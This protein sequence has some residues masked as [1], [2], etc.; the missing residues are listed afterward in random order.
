MLDVNP[1]TIQQSSHQELIGCCHILSDECRCS[2][3]QCRHLA[4]A[5]C[6]P[7][8]VCVRQIRH[9]NRLVAETLKLVQTPAHVSETPCNLQA[10]LC[11]HAVEAQHNAQPDAALDRLLVFPSI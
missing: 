11:N 2:R 8:Q 1:Y 3:V 4:E 9:V 5:P 7:P 10:V 6:G